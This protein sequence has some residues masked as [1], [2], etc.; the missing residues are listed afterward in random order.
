MR[1]VFT[2]SPPSSFS[3]PPAQ[4]SLL[5][6]HFCLMFDSICCCRCN[7]IRLQYIYNIYLSISVYLARLVVCTLSDPSISG[8]RV[9]EFRTAMK[10]CKRNLRL[11]SRQGRAGQGSLVAYLSVADRQLDM[12]DGSQITLNGI[13]IE[14]KTSNKTM[15][16]P[17]P[18][19]GTDLC[20][21]STQT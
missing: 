5:C 7:F 9:N 21:C 1:V 2:R 20:P 16:P 3:L 12:N 19:N 15:R 4:S 18:D 13:S 10:S 14:A 11:Q 8:Q 17:S 6:W